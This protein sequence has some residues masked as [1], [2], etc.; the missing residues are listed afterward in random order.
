MSEDQEDVIS[1]PFLRYTIAVVAIVIAFLMRQF[2]VRHLGAEL[3]HYITFY[4]AVV[5]V[6]ILAGLGPG[7]LATV[8]ALL[9]TAY[10][11]LPPQGQFAIE[12]PPML[13]G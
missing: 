8:V 6:A 4:P 13:S 10:W 3:P 2:M 1:R 7:L 5:L 9:L 12:K 11:I